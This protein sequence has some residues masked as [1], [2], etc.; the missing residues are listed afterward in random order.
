LQTK[1]IER[2][3]KEQGLERIKSK[4]EEEELEK[5]QFMKGKSFFAWKNLFSELR[6]GEPLKYEHHFTR[7]TR[8]SK[9]KR[10]A[11]L[12][13]FEKLKKML[14]SLYIGQA[15]KRRW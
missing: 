6:Y 5:K 13:M 9:R 15:K 4:T 2:L 10:R 7:L 11:L 1:E 12:F 14:E 3:R 8:R